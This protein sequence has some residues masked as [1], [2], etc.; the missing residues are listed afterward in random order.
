V[1]LPGG[2]I[3][4]EEPQQAVQREIEEELGL[5]FDVRELLLSGTVGRVRT[6]IHPPH[7]GLAYYC[8]LRSGVPRLSPEIVSAEWADPANVSHNLAPFQRRAMELGQDTFNHD[9]HRAAS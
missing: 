6:S 3:G 2:W 7:L 4:G 5:Q 8:R 1:G 9:G